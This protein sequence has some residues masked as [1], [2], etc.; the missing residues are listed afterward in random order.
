MSHLCLTCVSLV[1]HLCLTCVS[2]FPVE[3]PRADGEESGLNIG[4]HREAAEHFLAALSQHDGQAKHK[5]DALYDSANLWA[6]LRRA[7]DALV[8]LS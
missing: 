5:A 1:S 4:V 3:K 8:N 2:I 6:S 7:L